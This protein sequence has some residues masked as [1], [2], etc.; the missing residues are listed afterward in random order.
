M[1]IHLFRLKTLPLTGTET[2]T[3]TGTG[4]GTG[5]GTEITA[6]GIFP[7]CVFLSGIYPDNPCFKAG[8]TGF[9]FPGK[10]PPIGVLKPLPANHREP[11]SHKTI[12]F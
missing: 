6:C 4:T 12:R 2:E 8:R 11:T 9:P 7:A 5:T 3:E 1:A 10:I